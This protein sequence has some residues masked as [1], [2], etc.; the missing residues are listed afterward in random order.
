MFSADS[1]I[2][3]FGSN[4]LL[5]PQFR[6]GGKNNKNRPGHFRDSKIDEQ[7]LENLT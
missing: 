5:L 4:D 7:F 2:L 6:P 1:E 3:Y